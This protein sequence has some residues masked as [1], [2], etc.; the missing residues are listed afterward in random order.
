MSK[1]T[2]IINKL[3]AL[4]AIYTLLAPAIIL[5]ADT[6][7]ATKS[8]NDDQKI[9]H[10]LNRLGFGARPG[11]VERVKTMGLQKYIDQQLNPSSIDDSATEAKVKNLD[12]FG[13]STSEIF[14]KY[15]NP[16][17][18]L[19]QL[20]GVKKGQQANAKQQKVGD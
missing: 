5:R 13:L 12:V 18:L 19:R 14:A 15:P 7:T 9:L 8:I 3:A 10:V 16:G 1:S 6:A 11:D 4:A 17:A 20:E 2:S